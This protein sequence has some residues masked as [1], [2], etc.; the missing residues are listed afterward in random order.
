MKTLIIYDSFFSNTQKVA[1]AIASALEKKGEVRV[2][3]VGD[4]KQGDLKGVELLI[5]GSPTRA[6]RPTPAIVEF[7]KN[8]PAGSLGGVKVAAFDTRIDTADIKSKFLSFM[9]NKFGYAAK[10]IADELVRA[11]GELVGEPTGFFV[12][13]KEGPLK[14]GEL[15][16]AGEWGKLW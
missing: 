8:I 16:R 5:V 2:V 12:A 15:K 9:V 7:I 10:P 4:V 3:R 1:E 13:D 14:P 11:G 6:F